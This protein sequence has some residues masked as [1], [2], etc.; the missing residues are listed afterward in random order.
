MIRPGPQVN[1][2]NRYIGTLCIRGHEYLN[3]GKSSRYKSTG[4]CVVC[5]NNNRKKAN[6]KHSKI[7]RRRYNR[8]YR[9]KNRV[10]LR[11]SQALYQKKNR[12]RIVLA[13]KKGRDELNDNYIKTLIYAATG[14]RTN[15]KELIQFKREQLILYR[16]IRKAK[17]EIKEADKL[18]Q[19]IEVVKKWSGE[20]ENLIEKEIDNNG[21]D[22]NRDK[23]IK[24]TLSEF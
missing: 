18:N 19:K 20:V 5:A 24:K 21:H 8:K 23:R 17:A 10:K 12:P 2:E 6:Y 3:T 7:Q 4:T 13:N 15:N 16:E 14:L 22:C 9:E 11:I 1:P